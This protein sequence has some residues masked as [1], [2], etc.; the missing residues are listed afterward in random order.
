MFGSCFRTLAVILVSD[1]YYIIIHFL[2]SVLLQ[3]LFGVQ[4]VSHLRW[5][6]HPQWQ[7][8]WPQPFSSSL[9][10][11]D[12]APSNSSPSPSWASND[13]ND[14]P[15]ATVGYRLQLNW[16]QFQGTTYTTRLPWAKGSWGQSRDHRFRTVV[17]SIMGRRS[18]SSYTMYTEA[19]FA[20]EADCG[21]MQGW[22]GEGKPLLL[23]DGSVTCVVSLAGYEA[24]RFKWRKKHN[25]GLSLCKFGSVCWTKLRQLTGELSLYIYMCL[26]TWLA[27]IFGREKKA[28][29]L[30]R[31]GS[32]C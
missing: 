17:P 27:S 21:Q 22:A 28:Y 24:K 11:S 14:P 10:Q 29:L 20:M 6:T 4:S 26:L 1:F 2:F 23:F 13:P 25:I 9:R 18:G 8:P 3:T 15:L 16:K 19:L 12:K 7:L 5:T 32:S 31:L 30:T